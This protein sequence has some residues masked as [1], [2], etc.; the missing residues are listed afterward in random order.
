MPDDQIA[1]WLSVRPS[2]KHGPVWSV[3]WRHTARDGTRAMKR[4]PLKLE[5]GQPCPAWMQE[6]DGEWVPR[7]GR[8]HAGHYTEAAAHP[9]A[10]AVIDQAERELAAKEAAG[11]PTTA[12]A[13]FR[14][15]W[16]GYRR[17]LV[18]EGVTPN[19]LA[20]YDIDFAEPGTKHKRGAGTTTGLALARLG[21]RPLKRITT[22][23]IDAL[24]DEYAATP[25]QRGPKGKP[26]IRSARTVNRLRQGIHAVLEWATIPRNGFALQRNPATHARV[27]KERKDH[28]V[29]WWFTWEETEAIARALEQGAH[30]APRTYKGKPLEESD[31]ELAARRV[32]DQRDADA[33]RLTFYTG[34]RL[35]ELTAMKL[36]QVRFAESKLIVNRSVSA[37]IEQ[38]RDKADAPGE[39]PLPDPAIVILDRLLERDHFKTDDDYLFVGRGGERISG[40]ALN[41]RFKKALAYTEL[42]H[43]ERSW[44]TLRHSYGTELV[45]GGADLASV[46]EAMRHSK[47]ATT[48]RYLHARSAAERAAKF[49]DIFAQAATPATDPRTETPQQ[50]EQIG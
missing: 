33:V 37:G 45:R 4:R 10:V 8:A 23:D 34:L 20:T 48:E 29:Q 7:K 50:S 25:Y 40:S 17:Y 30:R 35:N 39:V 1:Y 13:T 19:T 24:L 22:E 21:D 49:T 16:Q 41:K 11:R 42:P 27:R 32:E 2:A 31:D 26:Q 43:Q 15:A 3:R 38:E 9:V 36:R 46:K 5:D 14:D 6:V 28:S 18:E 12:R 44:H 47:L